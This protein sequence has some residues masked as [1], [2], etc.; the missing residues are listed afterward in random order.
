LVPVRLDSYVGILGISF[1]TAMQSSLDDHAFP[2]KRCTYTFMQCCQCEGESRDKLPSI[3]CS[4]DEIGRWVKKK[5]V[6]SKSG[7]DGMFYM[8]PLDAYRCRNLKGERAS[9]SLIT[10]LRYRSSWSVLRGKIRP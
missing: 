4:R 1:F 8:S 7:W 5:F 9:E 2:V 6:W 3:C 10:K